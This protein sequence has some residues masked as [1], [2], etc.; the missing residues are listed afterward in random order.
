M[1]RYKYKL[2]A[3]FA[4]I[5]VVVAC[6]K[7]YVAPG[8]P[9]FSD[10]A[11][12]VG[13]TRIQRDD[14]VSFADLSRGV[15]NRNWTLP[16]GVE[17]L[18]ADGAELSRMQTLHVQFNEPGEF[19]VNL[20]SE[21]AVD[22]VSLDTTFTVTVLDYVQSMIS[23][24]SVDAEH[25]EITES[26]VTMYAGGTVNFK[27]VSLGEP[28]R[29]TWWF[30]GGDPETAGGVSANADRKDTVASV[31]YKFVGTYDVQLITWRDF[32]E[33]EADTTLLS[34]YINVISNPNPP[35]VVGIE[36]N[37][38]G[39]VQIFFS[40]AMA[41]PL[42]ELENFTLMVNGEEREIQSIVRDPSNESVYNLTPVVSI[43]NSDASAT[44]AYSGG[45]ITSLDEVSLA[46]FGA[47]DINI[48]LINLFEI[49]D[50]EDGDFSINWNG[51]MGNEPTGVVAEVTN[52]DAFS[53]AYSLKMTMPNNPKNNFVVQSNV[54][55]VPL[56]AGKQYVLEYSYKFVGNWSGGEW[57][58]RF[59]PGSE[60]SD[61]MRLWNGNC[62]G[63]VL[64]GEWHTKQT[65]F[66]PAPGW[67]DFKLHYQQIGSNDGSQYIM[68][69]DN[70]KLYEYEP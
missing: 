2:L 66:N 43:K 25:S 8:N 44:L 49:G 11:A 30:E 68:Y 55:Q 22:T 64:D 31:Q 36:E 5:A 40:R 50:F 48:F 24:E 53:G 17:V 27:D 59:Q 45:G 20:S 46:D 39:V 18:N 10:P 14:F 52:E 62:C 61:A 58:F 6:D 29:R 35:T 21:F 19:E 60:W 28:D 3:L 42:N 26:Q 23:V 15:I 1:K 65:V 38:E 69:L 67:D 37:E 47:S 57:N 4:V 7:D 16:S 9:N 56:E 12:A 63:S 33:G 54:Q 32:P 13:Q 34:N 70:I 41:H 51:P